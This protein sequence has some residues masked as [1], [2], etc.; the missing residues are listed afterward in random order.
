MVTGDNITT[1]KAIARE[2]NIL[3]PDGLAVEGRT[4]RKMSYAE[5]IAAYGPKLEK[6][7]VTIEITPRGG[8]TTPCGTEITPP[9]QGVRRRPRAARHRA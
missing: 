2:V 3:T 6:L 8:E 7:Q 4:F 5:R 1:A 9:L